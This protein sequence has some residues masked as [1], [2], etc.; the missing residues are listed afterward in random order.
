ML[1]MLYTAED[2]HMMRIKGVQALHCGP[3]N[4]LTKGKAIQARNRKKGQ[5]S[6][7]I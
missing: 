5:A 2:R 3:Y 7:V 4:T 1:N 6:A